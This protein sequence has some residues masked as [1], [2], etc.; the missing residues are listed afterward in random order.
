MATLSYDKSTQIMTVLAPDTEITV[1]EIVNQTREFEDEPHN[2]E[3]FKIIDASGK[4][5]L[6]GGVLV[7]ITA[8]L[9]DW[10]IAF[11]ARP[12]PTY[13]LC[14]IS[15]GNL[16]NF[17]TG[18]ELYDSPVSP[19]AFV[20][21]TRTSSASATLQELSIIQFSSYQNMVW[22]DA[23]T[24][25]IGVAFPV[26]TREAPVNNL[27]D[28][29]S[30][31]NTK[32]FRK[33]GLLSNITFKGAINEIADITTVADVTSSLD[34]KYFTLYDSDE[35]VSFWIDVDNNGTAE[36]SHGSDRSV[37]I[38]TIVEDD[39]AD[40]V[41]S[42]IQAVINGD[43]DFSA[44]VST[45]VITV[46]DVATGSRTD[47]SAGT[48]GFTVNTTAQG[49]VLHNMDGYTI[50]GE[51]ALPP[52]VTIEAGA[53]AI[54]CTFVDCEI[55]GD[56]DGG[57]RLDECIVNNLNYV[58][59]F[60]MNSALSQTMTL[61]GGASAHIIN[62][63]SNK[64]V[65]G[66]EPAINMGGSGQELV[67]SAWE[68][69]LSICNKTGA[70]AATFDLDSGY[71]HI[72]STISNGALLFRG[73]GRILDDSTGTAVVTDELVNSA[74][75]SGAVWDEDQ[76]QHDLT[77]SFGELQDNQLKKIKQSIAMQHV[78]G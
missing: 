31:A 70:D 37:E 32:G 38:T 69:S 25:N 20:T 18:T 77:D 23:S 26:G 1:Q 17:D 4:E 27:N 52:I 33:L 78:K 28:A 56:L 74:N 50:M 39:D 63:H 42:K 10:K 40:T 30:I 57:N 24:S 35:S 67:V 3:I 47:G 72:E 5:N 7:G 73:I 58:N 13:I 68:G 46:T 64:A 66:S 2:M 44:T 14:D 60:I 53:N 55:V 29:F 76:T 59:G 36:P 12:G 49:A 21:V 9:L 75:I 22:V 71:I 45:N 11:E 6:G 43:A 51:T 48:S 15:G 62:C 65:I 34:G 8:T 16:V 61:G 54:N 19:T 41:A